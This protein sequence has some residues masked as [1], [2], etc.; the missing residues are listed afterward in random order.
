VTHV[1]DIDIH[2]A[3]YLDL[4]RYDRQLWFRGA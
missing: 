4:G 2:P 1:N 3:S